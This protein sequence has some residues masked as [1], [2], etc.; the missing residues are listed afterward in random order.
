M[1]QLP[2][3]MQSFMP[4]LAW[5]NLFIAPMAFV[6]AFLV[7]LPFVKVYDHQLCE[8]EAAEKAASEA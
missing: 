4:S 7:Y 3:I 2:I 8:K 1:T 5:Q 6:I